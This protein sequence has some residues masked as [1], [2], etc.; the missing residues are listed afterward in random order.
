[1]TTKII[2]QNVV[3]I[4]LL[5]GSWVMAWKSIRQLLE[6]MKENKDMGGDK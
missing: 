6:T 4:P 1:M 5:I 2:I 3:L